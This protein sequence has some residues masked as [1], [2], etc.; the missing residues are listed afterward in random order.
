M[1]KIIKYLFYILAIG[2][3]AG[4]VYIATLPSKFEKEYTATF[5]TI[6]RAVLKSKLIDFNAWKKW[7]IEDTLLF[8]VEA[9]KDPLQSKLQSS[10]VQNQ[11]YKLENEQITDSIVIQKLYTKGEKTVQTLTWK[12]GNYRSIKKIDLLVNEELSFSDKLMN[13]LS[14]ENKKRKWLLGIGEKLPALAAQV[15]KHA[16]DYT[17]SS[18][19]ETTFGDIH[20]IYMTASGSLNHIEKQTED[21][22]KKL[23]QYLAQSNIAIAGNPFTIVDNEL[24]YGDLVFSTAIPINNAIE[25]EKASAIRYDFISMAP[26]LS[27]T[28][29]GNPQNMVSL[30]EGF[31]KTKEATLNEMSTRKYIVYDTNN[32]I[33]N[34]MDKKQ[35]LVW[36]LSISEENVGKI[37]LESDSIK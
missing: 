23:E 9:S 17:L 3:I 4:S 12:L 24:A 29:N 8:K 18:V 19:K 14:W 35:H 6:P 36:Q 21:H 13:L 30:W 33:D 20:Y 26:V 11:E 34:P 32:Q 31:E 2:V 15:G 10:L 22:I 37:A 1:F 28:V 7:A 16:Y 27:I 25:M 5:N